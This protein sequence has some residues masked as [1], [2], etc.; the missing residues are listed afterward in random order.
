VNGNCCPCYSAMLNDERFFT[1][2]Y[3]QHTNVLD[4]MNAMTTTIHDPIDQV[5][6]VHGELTEIESTYY[7]RY[8]PENGG[9]GRQSILTHTRASFMFIDDA[10][11][12]FHCKH[13]AQWQYR[14]EHMSHANAHGHEPMIFLRFLF[15]FLLPFL[16]LSIVSLT[17]TIRR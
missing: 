15:F 13:I 16:F 6:L 11:V 4:N 3:H 1:M 5:R 7:R 9:S 2:H 12:R 10:I 17:L 8:S 14:V